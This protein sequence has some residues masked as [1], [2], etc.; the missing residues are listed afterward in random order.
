MTLV[1]EMA[2]L[3][4]GLNPETIP[5][6][7]MDRARLLLLDT[8]GCALGGFGSP[9]AEAVCQV[10]QQLGG[11]PESTVLGSGFRTS[12]V[13]ATL[14]NGTMIRYL[15]CND[16]YLGKSL[17]GHPSDNVAVALAVGERQVAS[18]RDVLASIIA[19]YEVYGRLQDALA[20]APRLNGGLDHVSV[21]AMAAAAMASR[22]LGLDDSGIAHAMAIGGSHGLTLSELRHGQIAMTK[23]VANAM[24]AQLGVLA[25]LL[26]QAGMTGPLT[27]LEGSHGLLKTAGLPG[28]PPEL[29][30]PQDSLRI[31]RVSIKPFCCI[32]TAQAMVAAAVELHR[33]AHLPPEE[34]VRVQVGLAPE[35]VAM[36]PEQTSHREPRTREVAD[37]S[38]PYLAAVALLDGPVGPAQFRP[39][40]LRAPEIHGLMG[41]I[42]IGPDSSLAGFWPRSSPANVTLTTSQGRTLNRRIEFPPGHPD[43]PMDEGQVLDKF[44]ALTSAILSPQD[45]SAAATEALRIEQAQTI[46]PLMRALCGRERK[47]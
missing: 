29:V 44:V 20:G 31:M 30:E 27:I 6:A 21:S 39:E 17:G 45:A 40:R 41:R 38:F 19:G 2:Q 24:V 25:S 34:I 43:N 3:V 46:S 15:D 33:T 36:Q 14:A 47:K 18:G 22:L 26:A 1:E 7:A 32:G 8:L 23:A 10:V 4:A 5:A 16:L 12:C 35:V 9:P 37:H 13:G 11:I 42:E 28:V